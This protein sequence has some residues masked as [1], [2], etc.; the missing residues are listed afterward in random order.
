MFSNNNKNIFNDT[1]NEL[2][3]SESDGI[4]KKSKITLLIENKFQR[5]ISLFHKKSYT[6]SH[7][8][9]FSFATF[10]H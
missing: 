5:Y 1:I 9:F 10:I 7:Y 3:D 8:P 4:R 2:S 6:I